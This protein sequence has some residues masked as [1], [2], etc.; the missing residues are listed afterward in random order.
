M[1][2]SGV[3]ASQVKNPCSRRLK[4]KVVVAFFSYSICGSQDVVSY[5]LPHHVLCS[6]CS[7]CSVN[8]KGLFRVFQG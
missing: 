7:Q 3:P 6:G 2:P 1:I 4:V 5:E 8:V